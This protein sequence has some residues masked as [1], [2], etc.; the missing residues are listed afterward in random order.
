[1]IATN[2]AEIEVFEAGTGGVPLLLVHGWPELAYSWRYQIEAL[3]DAGYHCIV[4]N[5]RGYGGSSKPLAHED[6]DIHHLSADL[7]GILDSLGIDEAIHVGHDWGAILVWQHALLQPQRVSAIANLSVP[8]MPR[9]SSDP[10]AFWRAALGDDFYIV[11]FNLQPD[12][13]ARAFEGNPR[14]VLRNL[15][16]AGQWIADQTSSTEGRSLIELADFDDRRG[17]PIMTE[18][19]LQVYVDAFSRGG[20]VAP[21]NWYRNFSRNWRTTEH[22]TQRIT[23]P[24]L[25]IYGRYDM[26]PQAN[27]SGFVDD[28]EVHTLDCGHWIQQEQPARTNGTLLTWLERVGPGLRCFGEV[29]H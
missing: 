5:Q 21:I 8:F 7:S 13:A 10:V 15:Y 11:H 29:R 9:P 28:L 1:M 3:V 17:Y 20:F 26:V 19:D 23:Q 12:V 16:R 4:P 27:M 2:N 24:T 18:A 6:Y 14:R 22:L 25:M